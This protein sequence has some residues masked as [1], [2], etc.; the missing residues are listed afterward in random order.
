[1]RRRKQIKV[2]GGAGL[3][4]VAVRGIRW[5]LR[6]LRAA[7]RSLIKDR[8]HDI[9][10]VVVGRSFAAIL[11]LRMYLFFVLHPLF[12]FTKTLKTSCD[13]TLL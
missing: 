7:G 6:V 13:L 10:L 2:V 5:R 8:D 12:R 9:A 1:M 3:L 4:E 11:L